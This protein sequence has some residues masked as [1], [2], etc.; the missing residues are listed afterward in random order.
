MRGFVTAALFLQGILGERLV[1][2][3]VQNAVSAQ[4]AQ[5]SG[6][7]GDYSSITADDALPVSLSSEHESRSPD[8][9][10]EERATSTTYWYET[11]AHQGISAFNAN[12]ATYKVYRN[13]KDY[14]AKGYE[15]LVRSYLIPNTDD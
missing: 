5:F 12:K 6:Y 3:E 11:I 14:G 4:L 7:T 10:L 8:A 2:P 1:I 15:Y 9:T 13:V